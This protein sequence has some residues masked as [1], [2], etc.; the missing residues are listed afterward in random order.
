MFPVTVKYIL[1]L[2]YVLLI[3][4]I[5]LPGLMLHYSESRYISLTLEI[6]IACPWDIQYMFPVLVKYTLSKEQ[7]YEILGESC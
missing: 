7:T 5:V 1:A 3:L 2:S 4:D 6:Y